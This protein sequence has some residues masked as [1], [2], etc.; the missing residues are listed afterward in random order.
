MLWYFGLTTLTTIG[1]GDIAP[2]SAKE[3]LFWA[4]VMMAGVIIFSFICGRLMDVL[5]SFQQL[6]IQKDHKDLNQ[7]IVLLGRFN[8]S[9]QLEKGLVNKIETHFDYYWEHNRL[10]PFQ[11]KKNEILY[12]Q[13][14]EEVRVKLYTKYLFRDFVYLFKVYIRIKKYGKPLT[15]ENFQYRSFIYEILN[16]LQPRRYHQKTDLIQE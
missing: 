5:L 11:D 14:S 4:F 1:F 7:W 12:M 8:N 16:S 13:L 6:K 9:V 2:K 3:K 15:L 10:H